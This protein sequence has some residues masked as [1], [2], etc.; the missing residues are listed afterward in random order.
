MA[1][2]LASPAPAQPRQSADYSKEAAWLCLPGRADPCSSPIAT[3]EL[4]P[5]GYGAKRNTAPAKDPAV[6]CFYVYPTVSSDPG[7]NSDLVPG[8]EERVIAEAQMAR[9][10]SV[11]RPFA[12]L[13][14]QMTVAAIAAFATGADIKQPGAIAYGDV[15]AAFRDYLRRSNGRP[16]VLIGHSQGSLMIQQLIGQVI[17]RDP[18]L[19]ERMKLAI[20]P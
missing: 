7:L 3:T 5:N 18:A 15:V 1:I 8:R 10:A 2:L 4:G 6:D 13:Y 16:F 14:R 17:E 12:P 9:F 20:I 11:C 19:A